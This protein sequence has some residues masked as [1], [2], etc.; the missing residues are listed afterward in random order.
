MR[1]LFTFVGGNG[2]Y[3]PLVPIARAARAAGHTV[4]FTGEPWFTGA[5]TEFPVHGIGVGGSH[6]PQRTPLVAL[7]V[8]HEERVLTENFARRRAGL[9]AAG[10]LELC[11]QWRP[12]LLVI[13]E[14]DFGSVIAAERLGLPYARVEVTASGAFCRTE[15]LVEPLNELRAVH[16]LPPDPELRMLHRNLVL[17]PFPPSFRHPA[18]PAPSTVHAVRPE[19]AVD[20]GAAAPPWLV[21]LPDQPTVY[22]TLGTIFN[23]ECGDLYERVLAG[24]A[25]LP[26]N[27]IATVGSGFDP[28]EL[29]PQP[30]NVRVERYVPQGLVLPRCDAVVSHGGSGSVI[31]ALAHGLPMVL[32]PMGADQ[33][34]NAD[35]CA[36]LGVGVVLDALLASS[37]EVGAAVSA[38]LSEPGY[39]FAAERLRVEIDGL[40]GVEHALRLLEGVRS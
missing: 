29:G 9:R 32:V 7:D 36:D 19:L 28:A 14:V 11:A 27:V 24:L 6:K 31:G 25:E 2:H 18:H 8:A 40:P 26:V 20:E 39:R 13:E 35:R 37:A 15:L 33:P 21:G 23:L 3:Q 38:V 12:D 4:A 5:V 34:H 22:F 16:G 17:A 10:L 30:P 1:I